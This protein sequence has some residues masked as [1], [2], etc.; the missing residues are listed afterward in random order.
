VGGLKRV[1][2]KNDV[3]V[4]E[5]FKDI[6]L[7]AEVVQLFFSFATIS[8]LKRPRNYLPF[9]NEFECHNLARPFASTFVDLSEGAFADGVKHVILVHF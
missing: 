3:L 9:S 6:D 5:S 1:K 7:L 8:R 2:E 4:V